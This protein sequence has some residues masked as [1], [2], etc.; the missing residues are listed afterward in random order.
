MAACQK[1]T[2]DKI[3]GATERSKTENAFTMVGDIFLARSVLF[4]LDCL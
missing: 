1:E 2:G 3:A 4:A